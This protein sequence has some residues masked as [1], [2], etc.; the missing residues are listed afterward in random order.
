MYTPMKT[1]QPNK[2]DLLIGL[3]HLFL[4]AIYLNNQGMVL[5]DTLF[6]RLMEDIAPAL[7]YDMIYTS[8]PHQSY[9]EIRYRK[10][11]H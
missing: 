5:D 2:N 8:N 4:Y 6:A 7:G 11:V 1:R 3:S 9:L 10:K